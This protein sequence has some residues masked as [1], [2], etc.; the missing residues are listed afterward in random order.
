MIHADLVANAFNNWYANVGG[1]EV[2]YPRATIEKN[3]DLFKRAGLDVIVVEDVPVNT[4]RDAMLWFRDNTDWSAFKRADF[5][6]AY[7]AL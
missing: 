3:A 2:A 7:A 5:D 6:T 4:L 1:K